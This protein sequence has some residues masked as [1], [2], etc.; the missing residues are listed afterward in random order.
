MSIDIIIYD[1][2]FSPLVFELG[3]QKYIAVESVYAVFEVKQDLTKEHICL[4]LQ[5]YIEKKPVP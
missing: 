1:T 3:E 4:Y 5:N 2:H